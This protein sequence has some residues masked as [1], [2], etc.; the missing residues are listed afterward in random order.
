[1]KCFIYL[2]N[3]FYLQHLPFLYNS[4]ISCLNQHSTNRPSQT[5]ALAKKPDI[6]QKFNSQS[7]GKAVIA[8]YTYEHL[9]FL[10]LEKIK[11]KRGLLLYIQLH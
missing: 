10:L 7:S 3:N 8:K 2:N 6:L 4:R 1:M 5:L 11:K 9:P